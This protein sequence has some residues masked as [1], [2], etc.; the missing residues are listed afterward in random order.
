MNKARQ[1]LEKA[2]KFSEAVDKQAVKE[3]ILYADNDGDL[4]KRQ[5][6]PILKNLKKKW[7]KGQFDEKK[8][9][10]AF[11]NFADEAA[12]KYVKEHGAP[13]DK[14]KDIFPKKVR[15]A[16]A[17]EWAERFKEQVENDDLPL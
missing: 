8:A 1:V 14:V 2:K 9:V 3:L 10:K 15:E 7:D 12:K 17:E 11:L 6:V 5:F 4:H 13:G 16:A